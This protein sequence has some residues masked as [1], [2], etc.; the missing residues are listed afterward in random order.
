MDRFRKRPLSIYKPESDSKRYKSEKKIILPIFESS[1]LLELDSNSKKGIQLKHTEPSDA[2]SLKSFWEKNNVQARNRS[3]HQL[4]VYKKGAK[5]PVKE[6]DLSEESS[7]LIGRS[8]GRSLNQDED[9]EEGGEPKEVVIAD[10]GIPEETCSKQHCVIQFRNVNDSIKAYLLDLDSSNGTEL[11]GSLIP[12]ARYVE[13]RS[14]DIITLSEVVKDTDY[15]LI[16]VN[17]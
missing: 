2:E 16:F 14:G 5:I 4:I 15:E 9:N 8:L 17:D 10:I 6:Y 1:G 7:Y 13:L 11:N 12:S 3:I